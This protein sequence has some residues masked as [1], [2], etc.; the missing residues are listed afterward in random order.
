MDLYVTPAIKDS[1]SIKL[2]INACLVWVIVSA[3]QCKEIHKYV[4]LVKLIMLT[5]ET[6]VVVLFLIA[7][8]A[9]KPMDLCAN[10][11]WLDLFPH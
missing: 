8:H 10:S 11:A 9:H 6:T 3:A 5:M 2:L 1:L 4:T 7:R